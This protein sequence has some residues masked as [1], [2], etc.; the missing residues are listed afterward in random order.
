MPNPTQLLYW[1]YCYHIVEV[2]TFLFIW[3]IFGLLSFGYSF[4]FFR[5]YYERKGTPKKGYWDDVIC[6]I[7]MSLGGPISLLT[8]VFYA[9]CVVGRCLT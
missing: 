6:C 9:S 3:F 7:V 1:V 4:A 2:L 8:N 5:E